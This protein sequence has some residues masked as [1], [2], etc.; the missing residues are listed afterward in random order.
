MTLADQP[1]GVSRRTFLTCTVTLIGCAIAPG[2]EKVD[3]QSAASTPPPAP[4]PDPVAAAPSSTAP[5]RVNVIVPGRLAFSDPA[6]NEPIQLVA[7][8]TNPDRTSILLH[9]SRGRIFRHSAMDSFASRVH[10][11]TGKASRECLA[12]KVLASYILAATLHTVVVQR[13]R[14]AFERWGTAPGEQLA[15]DR[16]L[17]ALRQL[18]DDFDSLQEQDVLDQLS[19]GAV[20]AFLESADRRFDTLS[21]VRW[22]TRQRSLVLA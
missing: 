2:C 21:G 3:T 9:D 15:L 20:Y 7:M 10:G 12:P 18:R 1:L 13:T 16:E 22:D 19:L 5:L 4:H 17:S 14:V 6:V 8:Q 11:R